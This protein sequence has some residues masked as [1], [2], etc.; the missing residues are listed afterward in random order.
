M[1][2]FK[3]KFDNQN[4]NILFS[5]SKTVILQFIISNKISYKT[6]LIFT[7]DSITIYK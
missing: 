2:N 5:K 3:T 1:N 7:K 4:A 6:N